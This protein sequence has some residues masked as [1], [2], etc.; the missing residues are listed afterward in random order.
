MRVIISEVTLFEKSY[1]NLFRNI[2]ESKALSETKNKKI[3]ESF[4]DYTL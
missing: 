3:N 1:R 4:S 2:K